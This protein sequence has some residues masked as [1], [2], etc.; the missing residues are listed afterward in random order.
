M[1]DM[2]PFSLLGMAGLSPAAPAHL[3]RAAFD[4]RVSDGL[5]VRKKGGSRNP[6]LIAWVVPTSTAGPQ[7]LVFLR[8]K[9]GLYHIPFPAPC[10]GTSRSFLDS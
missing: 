6:D 4:Q 1:L 5:P 8:L 3:L 9:H 7:Y 2:V 10:R